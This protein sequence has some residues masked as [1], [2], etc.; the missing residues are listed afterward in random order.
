METELDKSI[1]KNSEGGEVFPLGVNYWPSSSAIDMW[2]EWLPE[3]VQKDFELMHEIG[4]NVCRFFIFMPI[5]F[6]KP[7][8][9]SSVMLGKLETFLG[10]AEK[11]RVYTFPTLF[12]GHMSGEDWDLDWR[13]G[14][15][16]IT[17]PKMIEAEKY[18][19]TTIVEKIKNHSSIIGWIISNE[20]SNYVKEQNPDAVANWTKEITSLIKSLDPKRPVSLGDGAWAPEILGKETDFHLRLLNKY[21]D[22]VGLHY[23]P[24]EMD[25]W[26]HS[27][28]TAF[29]LRMAQEWGKPVFIEEFGNSTT[30]ASEENQA[31]Y[32][33]SVFHSA[34][35]NNSKGVI[36]WCFSD[37]D[38]NKKCPYSHHLLEEHFGA[39]RTDRTLKPAAN[40]FKK[41]S[42]LINGIHNQGYTKVENNVGL[43][44]PS[45]YYYPYPYLYE[46]AF[47]KW[48]DFYL[49]CFSLLKRSNFEVKMIVESP[50][51]IYETD[52]VAPMLSL[53][54]NHFSLVFSPRMKLLTKPFWRK[55]NKYINSGG[56]LYYSFSADSWVPDWDEIAGV[57][58]DCKFG[59]PDFRKDKSLEI[60]VE[61][62]WGLFN[63]DDT[64][65]IPLL[66][67]D[68]EF[69]YCPVLEVKGTVIMRDQ[70]GN[71][72]LTQ[73][74]IGS[75]KVIFS[76]YPLEM[77]SLSSLD[78]SWKHTLVK[79]YKSIY[80]TVYQDCDITLDGDGLEMGIWE[81]SE[82][83]T[84]KVVILNHSWKNE[85]G[86]LK[87]KEHLTVIS[88]NPEVIPID[89]GLYQI[90]FERK[91]VS[92][93]QIQDLHPE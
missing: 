29:R 27:F 69:G 88:N 62:D 78:S 26:R 31:N 3:E 30:L 47:D 35:I 54:N 2:T 57:K 18:Y 55:L 83:R 87:M 32:Y 23:Y 9:I 84:C 56:T 85:I 67:T 64:F 90:K 53:D 93:I 20:L 50:I 61:R 76:S 13:N 1:F 6:K 59:V 25:S 16:F 73:N 5:F 66:D 45:Y 65:Y 41:F 89:R 40:E 38:T 44:I 42:E 63:K 80:K 19:V 74:N 75:G 72:V 70:Y 4:L 48:Y 28:T 86:I 36:S 79:I 17:D 91:G 21:Q 49:E 82:K 46:P 14:R 7:N 68:P 39:I 37:F 92:V 22:V 77:L 33:R 81:N 58:T 8:E 71:P 24:R 43:V 15:N 51:S 11:N 10:I 60:T 12:V 52:E 34:I